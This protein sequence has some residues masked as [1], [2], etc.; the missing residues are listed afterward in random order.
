MSRRGPRSPPSSARTI[1]AFSLAS[2]PRSASGRALSIPSE[3]GSMRSRRTR[4]ASS[5]A[6]SVCVVVVISSSPSAP[7]TTSARSEPS[8][9]SAAASVSTSAGE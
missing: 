5:Q 4:P 1:A 8:A 2:P 7:C 6:A 9:P 3:T